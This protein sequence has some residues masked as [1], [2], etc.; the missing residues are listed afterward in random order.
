MSGLPVVS[1]DEKIEFLESVV[2]PSFEFKNSK[3]RMNWNLCKAKEY[4]TEEKAAELVDRFYIISTLGK[5]Q[6]KLLHVKQEKQQ[7]KD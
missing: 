3:E 4:L 7:G 1:N 6:Q 2:I 5:A